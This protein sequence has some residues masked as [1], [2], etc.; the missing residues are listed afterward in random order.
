MGEKSRVAEGH[1]LPRGVLSS[2]TNGERSILRR[3]RRE[4]DFL[5]TK[6]RTRA[7]QR[8]FGVKM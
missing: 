6:Q 8:H 2:S 5:N 4:R 7:N 1:E 3:G